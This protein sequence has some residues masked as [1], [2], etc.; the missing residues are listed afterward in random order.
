MSAGFGPTERLDNPNMSGHTYLA[1]D[2]KIEPLVDRWYAWP[3]LLA[4]A[5]QAMNLAFRYLSIARSFIEDPDL[6]FAAASDPSMLGG[7]FVELPLEAVDQMRS[8]I[9]ETELNRAPALM[10]AEEFRRFDALL[11][12]SAKGSSLD[13]FRER[14]PSA[15]KGLIEICYDLNNNPKIRILEEMFEDDDLGLQQA[16]GILLHNQ[17]DDERPFFLSTPR[18]TEASGLFIP[19]Q[20]RSEAVQMLCRARHTAVDAQHLAKSLGVQASSLARYLTDQ[21][22]PEGSNREYS[23]TGVRIRYFGHA[24]LLIQTEQTTILIDPTFTQDQ[25]SEP[26]FR[27]WDL[28]DTIDYLILSHGHQDHLCPEMLLQLLPKVKRVLVPAGRRGEIADP[29]LRRIMSRLGYKSIETIEPLDEVVF[30]DGTITSLPFSGEHADLDIHSK[31]CLLVEI[32]GRR[33]GIFI[34]SDAIDPDVYLRLLPRLANLDVMFVGMECYG[35]P[36][37]WLY[38]P[39]ITKPIQKS[40]DMSRR[41]S[42]SN[43]ERAWDLAR[44]I[45]PRYAFVY[46]MGQEPW[47]RYLMGLRYTE[48]SIQLTEVRRFIQQCKAEGIIAES[49]FMKKE[50]EI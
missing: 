28:P 37:S 35:A 43:C 41:L 18:V 6:H 49:L 50:L 25:F 40:H 16:Q 29:S 34:D 39:L 42:G 13:E 9:T 5:P 24:C 47:M 48:D 32:R 8:Y 2:A 1:S 12:A 46:A 17:R 21:P 33:I 38:G 30:N 23:G 45:R 22:P 7:P 4:P 15:L 36:L 31:H 19:A 10:F 26:H 44:P 3:H 27:L 14:V 20:F 11:Q